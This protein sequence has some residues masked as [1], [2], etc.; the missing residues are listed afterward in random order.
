MLAADD[1]GAEVTSRL[2]FWRYPDYMAQFPFAHTLDMTYRLRDGIL[3]V[4]TTIENQSTDPMPVS[5]G[6]HPYFRLHDSPRNAWRVTLPAKESYVLSSSLVASGEKRPMSYKVR[7]RWK[8]F[9]SMMFS[10]A[11]FPIGTEEPSSR[12]RAPKNVSP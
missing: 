10:A 8:G 7:R 11:S 3:E 9:P 1:K 4:E 6:F 12:S 5:V 2:E